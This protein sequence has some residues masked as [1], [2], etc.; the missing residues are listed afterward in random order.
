MHARYADATIFICAREDGEKNSWDYFLV[1]IG[2]LHEKWLQTDTRIE[3]QLNRMIIRT[4]LP[5]V[6]AHAERIYRH[7]D[8]IHRISALN[9]QALDRVLN[10]HSL[11]GDRIDTKAIP[12]ADNYLV[13]SARVT[14]RAVLPL[15]RT[16][17]GRFTW[18][19][20]KALTALRD[21]VGDEID[22]VHLFLDQRKRNPHP[23]RVLIPRCTPSD[24]T[25]RIAALLP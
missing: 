9:K 10:T 14:V 11:P 18:M 15:A 6:F 5:S 22:D 17:G 8:W 21:V 7:N 16:R 25:A 23:W 19:R 12:I 4:S 1:G 3:A 2:V 20:G 24:A 13:Y